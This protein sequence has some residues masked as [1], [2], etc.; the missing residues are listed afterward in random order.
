MRNPIKVA[1][2]ALGGLVVA[3]GLVAITLSAVGV[4]L[5]DSTPAGTASVPAPS[6]SPSPSP[7][8]RRTAART[9]A[10]AVLQAEAQVL[11]MS[12]QQLAQQLRQGASV[13][14]LAAQRGID[15]ASF[16]TRL[17][18]DVTPIL[19]RDVQSG[20]LTAAQERQA[21]RRLSTRIPRWSQAGPTPSAG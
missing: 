17:V 5:G 20:E 13:S 21:L 8:P 14:Q 7:A 1:I 12:P 16:Q 4:H 9:V 2:A 19:D 3:V 6:G 10:Q 15:Q 11:G 18:Q